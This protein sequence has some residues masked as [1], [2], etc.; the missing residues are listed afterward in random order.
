MRKYP[1]MT[2]LSW[3]RDISMIHDPNEF[4]ETDSTSAKYRVEDAS[5]VTFF[6]QAQLSH[7]TF[8]VHIVQ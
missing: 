3:K 5:C 8:P 1:N 2:P 7:L 6:S 4:L